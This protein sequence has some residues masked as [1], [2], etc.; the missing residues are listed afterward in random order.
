MIECALG[1][2]SVLGFLYGGNDPAYLIA[3]GLFAIAINL[4]LMKK[5][6]NR[7]IRN[8]KIE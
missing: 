5:I 1:L 3:A 8:G 6:R 4:T 7:R 2:L